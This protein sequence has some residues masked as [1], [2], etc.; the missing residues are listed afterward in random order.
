MLCCSVGGDDAMTP[1]LM[2]RAQQPAKTQRSAS[3]DGP[4]LLPSSASAKDGKK[5]KKKLFDDRIR[6]G[7]T[8]PSATACH[9]EFFSTQALAMY[10][11]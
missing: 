8:A 7:I 10:G 11:R 6:I 1:P 3:C 2:W 9:P 4:F 5:K